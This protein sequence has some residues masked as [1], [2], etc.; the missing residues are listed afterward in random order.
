MKWHIMPT[1][2]GMGTQNQWHESP[3]HPWAQFE[4]IRTGLAKVLVMFSKVSQGNQENWQLIS[5]PNF[6]KVPKSLRRGKLSF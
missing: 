4:V 1:D 2:W 6:G 5:K 3:L